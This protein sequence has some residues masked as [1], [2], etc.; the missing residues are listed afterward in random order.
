M[1][2]CNTWPKQVVQSEAAWKRLWLVGAKASG[3]GNVH[4]PSTHNAA[5][6]HLVHHGRLLHSSFNLQPLLLS[7]REHQ[8]QLSPAQRIG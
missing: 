4:E 1:G 5:D 2:L 6:H 3:T 8:R 7:I